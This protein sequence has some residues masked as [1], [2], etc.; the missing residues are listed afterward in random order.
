MERRALTPRPPPGVL[1]GMT[2]VRVRELERA[3]TN[4]DG[5][6]AVALLVQ[7]VRTGAL[8]RKDLEIAAYFGDPVAERAVGSTFR[9]PKSPVQV[10]RTLARW[11]RAQLIVAG[12]LLIAPALDV[13]GWSTCHER[14]AQEAVNAA[15]DW[16]SCP[17]LLHARACERAAGRSRNVQS[18]L[19]WVTV[20]TYRTQQ[21]L[22]VEGS[23]VRRT[24]ATI[25]ELVLGDYPE[26][27]ETT[28]REKD[29]VTDLVTYFPTG[30]KRP[31]VA[32][33]LLREALA[34]DM[35]PWAL[36]LRSVD[37]FRV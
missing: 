15:F 9:V 27:F 30:S 4:G 33:A 5:D 7:R 34:A 35:R 8:E 3:A 18:A 12:R 11:G 37:A 16:V 32:A 2:D 17:C 36:G 19:T 31:R 21:R 25:A 23:R 1:A 22:P 20:G 26:Q 6:A 13:L 10:L 14:E 24:A 29:V 28:T